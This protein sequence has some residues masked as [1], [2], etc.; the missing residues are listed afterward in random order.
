MPELSTEECRRWA[1]RRVAVVNHALRGIPE[2]R[3]R[4]HTCYSIDIGP[5]V[6]DMPL[7]DIADIFLQVK[8]AA[9]SFEYSNPRHEHEHHF[10]EDFKLPDGKIL[11]PGMVSHTTHLVEHPELV[12]ERVVR[13]ANI[14]GR[15]NLIAG[16]DCGFAAVPRPDGSLDIQR[17]IIWAKL[18]ALTEGARLASKKLWG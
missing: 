8:A 9:Y 4:F 2:D 11:I 12:A 7:K 17:E 15:E 1:Q 14:V 10:W 18:Q 6:H 5:R 13:Y 3:V 16:V